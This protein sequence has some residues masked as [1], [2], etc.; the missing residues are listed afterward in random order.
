[1]VPHRQPWPRAHNANKTDVSV[2]ID[3]LRSFIDVLR[4][5]HAI[6]DIAAPVDPAYQ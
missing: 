1:M 3:D 6:H 4:H 2:P 5:A